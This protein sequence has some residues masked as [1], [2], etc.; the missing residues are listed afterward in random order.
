MNRTDR[1]IAN[2]IVVL[3][4]EFD[5]W[6]VLFNP[7][8]AAAVGINPV[9]VAIWKR[10]DGKRSLKEIVLEIKTSFEDAPEAALEEITAFVDKLAEHGYVGY[11]LKDDTDHRTI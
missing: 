10:M 6:A 2:P 7:D 8:T 11:E 9:G 5:D 4:E 3:R 1:P